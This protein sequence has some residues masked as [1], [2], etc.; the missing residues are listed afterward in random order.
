MH[1]YRL[2]GRSNV[3]KYKNFINL[4]DFIINVLIKRIFLLLQLIFLEYSEDQRK[5]FYCP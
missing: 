4:R 5:L 2:K 3:V 1:F